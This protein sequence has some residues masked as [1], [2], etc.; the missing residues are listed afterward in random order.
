M[1]TTTVSVVASRSEWMRFMG[2]LAD[3]TPILD[4]LPELR[5]PVPH[6]DHLIRNLGVIRDA[7][8]RYSGSSPKIPLESVK[9]LSPVANPSK[10]IAAPLN[11]TQHVEEAA[12]DVE[13]HQKTHTMDFEGYSTPIEK[14]GLFLKSSTSVAGAGEGI[15]LKSVERRNDHEMELAV[16]IGMEANEVSP[17]DALGVVAGYCIGLDMSIRGTEDRSYRK[18]P[19]TYTLLGP[20]LV[21]AD[22]I[23][24]PSNLEFWLDVNGERRQASNTRY[25]LVDIADLISLASH[26]YRLYPGDVI[27]TGTPEGVSPVKRGDE[28]EA[29]IDQIGQMTVPV[30]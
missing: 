21:T 6:G 25:L 24:S 17:D 8:D 9:L 16:V 27:L 7:V 13:I 19:D 18:S 29:W 22:E 2:P 10:V 14:L 20:Y 28:I 4:L 1:A 23:A 12:Q 11:Y 5:W 15:R 26:W 3:I 30:Y